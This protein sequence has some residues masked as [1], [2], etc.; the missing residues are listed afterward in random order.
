MTAAGGAE[1]PV[2]VHRTGDA[3]RVG[4]LELNRP[5]AL[6]ALDHPMVGLMQEALDAWRDDDGVAVVVI[7]GRGDRGLCAGGDIVSIYHDARSG[8]R[9]SVAYWAD[10]Y[11][12][13]HTLATYPKPVVVVMDGIVLGGGVGIA[14][15]AAHRVVTERSSIG[16]PE[17]GIGFVPDVGGTWLL[18][19]APGETGT[20][21]ALTAGSVG[22]ADALATGLADVHVPS[23]RIPELLAALEGGAGVEETLAAVAT[24]PEQEA[25]LPGQRAWIDACYTGDDPVAVLA[26]LRARPEED[27]QRAAARLAERSPFAVT[28]TLAALRRA[29]RAPD[30]AT[31]LATDLRLVGNFLDVPDFAEGVRAQV[32]DKD[33]RPA[34]TPAT[35]EEVDPAAVEAVFAPLPEGDLVLPARPR[36][37]ED[38][39]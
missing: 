26:R 23:A 13:D 25:V 10:E 30:L 24:P 2:V 14:G 39:R 5:R 3:G 37:Q 21:L 7:T 34:W 29:E 35:L 16:M 33:R 31:V 1:P 27:A 36:P 15:H 6:N 12:L 11:V 28:V 4:R 38:R 20:H 8:G 18:A 22:A 9:A 32:I 19:R 17:T